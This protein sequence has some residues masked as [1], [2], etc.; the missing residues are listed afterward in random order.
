MAL[1][2][3]ELAPSASAT[4]E[5]VNAPKLS[6]VTVPKDV[7]PLNSSTT[8]LAS[9]V[10]TMLT[11]EDEN[12]VNVFVI[13]GAAGAVVSSVMTTAGVDAGDL[14]FAASVALAVKELAPSASAT[15]ENVNAPKLSAVTVPKD[16]SPLNSS[17]TE[18]AS[19]VP[20]M[21]TGEDATVQ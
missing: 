14:L 21:L 19:A 10:P 13:T 7:S 18:L 11:G 17:T 20:T 4:L 5:N 2:V 3:K 8:E 9:A 16:V 12:V 15:L 1:A 6:A